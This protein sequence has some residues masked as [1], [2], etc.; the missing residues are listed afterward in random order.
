MFLVL[1]VISIKLIKGKGLAWFTRIHAASMQP[2]GNVARIKI[3]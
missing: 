3:R 1:D 2:A